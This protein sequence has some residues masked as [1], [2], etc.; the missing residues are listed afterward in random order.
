MQVSGAGGA[1][2]GPARAGVNLGGKTA[3]L[4]ASP[5]DWGFA[6]N[7]W[8]DTTVPKFNHPAPQRKKFSFANPQPIRTPFNIYYNPIRRPFLS[9]SH[10]FRPF[11]PLR[12]PKIIY[13]IFCPHLAAPFKNIIFAGWYNF[14]TVH[15][16]VNITNSGLTSIANSSAH[17]PCY[18]QGEMKHWKPLKK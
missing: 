11:S 7:V 15:Y 4:G 13:L 17:C 5:H 3:N 1:L 2:G 18:V 8:S 9:D 6:Y 16:Y 12:R 14:G 10:Q